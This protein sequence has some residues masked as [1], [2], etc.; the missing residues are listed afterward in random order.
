M[1]DAPL[2]A[3]IY[4]LWRLLSLWAQA[5]LKLQHRR[6]GPAP[7]VPRCLAGNIQT[8]WRLRAMRLSRAR[9]PA[10]RLAADPPSH[11]LNP[12]PPLIPPKFAGKAP[13]G[14]PRSVEDAASVGAGIARAKAK[15]KLSF[16]NRLTLQAAESAALGLVRSCQDRTA[17]ACWPQ[18]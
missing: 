15:A 7:G 17:K 12:L 11:L 3:S 10:E 2:C 9:A 8:S 14:Y 13:R 5:R 4:R 1:F 16:R 6:L 18:R